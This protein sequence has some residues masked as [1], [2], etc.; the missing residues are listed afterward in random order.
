[1]NK[2][3]SRHSSNGD[4]GTVDAEQLLRDVQD[5]RNLNDRALRSNNSHSRG[6]GQVRRGTG[7]ISRQTT[8]NGR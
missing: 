4:S 7:Q 2:F 6:L 3:D 1:M 5:A 8:H